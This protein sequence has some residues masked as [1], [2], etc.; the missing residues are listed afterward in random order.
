[1]NILVTGGAGF[2]GSNFVIRVHERRPSWGV[3][4]LDS[5]TYAANLASLDSVIGAIEVVKGS[6]TDAALV[7]EPTTT[8]LWTTRGRS[9]TRISS[10][11][12][13]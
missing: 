2:I 3:T 6:V 8:T 13:S 12:T 1:V 9:S 7:D 10:A 4:V 5:M 11:P